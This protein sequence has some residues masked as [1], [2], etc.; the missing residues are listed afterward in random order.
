MAPIEMHAIEFEDKYILYRP[1]AGLA[2]VGNLALFE[3]AKRRVGGEDQKIDD[4][5]DAFLDGA[6]F[7]SPDPVHARDF[8]GEGASACPRSVAVLLM[9][10]E[11]NLRCRYCYARGGEEPAATLDIDTA[12]AAIDYACDSARSHGLDSFSLAFHGGGE[13][14][15]NWGVL[16]GSVTYARSRSL[17]CS[18]SMTSNGVWNEGQRDF[19][20]R[21]VDELNLSF[22]GVEEVQDSQRPGVGGA[23]SFGPAMRSIRALDGSKPRYGIRMTVTDEYLSELPRSVAFLCKETNCPSIQVEP[24]FSRRRG[25]YAE[26]DREQGERF[27][28]IFLEAFDVAAERGRTL[29]Y[30]GARPW[31]VSE[32]FCRAPRE[33]LIVTPER[34][35]VACFEVYGR[36]HPLF[37]DFAIGSVV[38]GRVAIDGTREAAMLEGREARRA[39]CRDCFNLRHC[40]GDCDS[41]CLS[42]GGDVRERC[43]VNRAITRGM[44]ARYIEKG[45][46]LYRRDVRPMPA[47]GPCT[48]CGAAGE[49]T[50]A[51]G[52]DRLS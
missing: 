13:P 21:S 12:R 3:Y 35:I 5:V 32:E 33:A 26:P 17:P 19:I 39:R 22:D 49:A 38:D 2:V 52:P 28:R 40:G 25:E 44:L 29:F 15:L 16:E 10:S 46:G 43:H 31:V 20:I 24:S 45:G 11:C 1:L 4:A 27:A 36:R 14:T 7:L 42:S 51:S 47:S 34:D 30:S 50:N 9:T 48:G 8:S 37:S 6:G 23:P 41:R 18:I